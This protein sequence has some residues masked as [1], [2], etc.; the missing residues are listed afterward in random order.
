MTANPD[1]IIKVNYKN[2][3]F[4]YGPRLVTVPSTIKNLLIGKGDK[5]HVLIRRKH[6]K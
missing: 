1:E 4:M 3:Q 5:S 2:K 6:I